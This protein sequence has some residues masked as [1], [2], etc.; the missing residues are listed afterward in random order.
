MIQYLIGPSLLYSD[1]S[2]LY[3]ESRSV[4]SGGADFL[5]LDVMDGHFVP[6]LT[7]G[8]PVIS[9]LSKN[10]SKDIILDVHLMVTHPEKWVVDMSKAGATIFTFHIESQFNH[11]QTLQLIENIQYHNMKVGIAVSPKTDVSTIFPY[12]DLI[13][14]VLIMTVE[15]GLGG[16]QFMV[17]MMEKVTA[18]RNKYPNIDIE[19][20]GGID[21]NTIRI[22]SNSGANMFVAGSFIFNS[23]DV[24]KSIH[25][26][27]TM[28][29]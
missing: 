19:V 2:K 8:A 22:A 1:L 20:D 5:H 18:V 26:L 11:K 15:P 7:F 16:Q 13:D 29:I 6:N 24:S 4:I 12:L 21:L 23:A 14:L 10:I 17:N 3:D 28:C 27:R 9:S 25:E